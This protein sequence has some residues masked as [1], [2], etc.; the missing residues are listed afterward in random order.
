[1]KVLKMLRLVLHLF[2]GVYLIAYQTGFKGR[3]AQD[4]IVQKAVKQ[5]FFKSCSLVGLTIKTHGE[6][7]TGPVLF[8]SNHVSWLDIPLVACMVNPR[9]LSKSEVR[10]WPVIGW[11]AEKVNTL[12]IVRGK[13]SAAEAASAAIVE[14]L[15][16]QDQILIFPEGT[17]TD[18]KT[19]AWVYPRLLGAAISVDA[20][21]QPIVLHYTDDNSDAEQSEIVPYIGEQ[22]LI[23]NLWNVLGCKNLTANVYFLEPAKANGLQRKEFAMSLQTAMQLSLHDSQIK[24]ALSH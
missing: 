7:A 4:P 14:G 3:S 6:Q 16:A 10:N 2:S 22:T 21:V 9:F 1:M 17:T 20:F 15:K 11:L 12:F 8:I 13:R 18:G 5:W 24:S 23:A 19:V